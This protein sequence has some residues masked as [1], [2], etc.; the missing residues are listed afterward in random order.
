M[1]AVCGRPQWRIVADA[2]TAH[3]EGLPKEIQR[4]IKFAVARATVRRS[5]TKRH[6]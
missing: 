1:A 6:R 2:L 4:R 5:Q 3:L